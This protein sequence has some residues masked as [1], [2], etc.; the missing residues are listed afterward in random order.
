VE[1]VVKRTAIECRG[2]FGS[3]GSGDMISLDFYSRSIRYQL[4]YSGSRCCSMR[5]AT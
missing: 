2:G 1:T 4:C 3:F 5:R